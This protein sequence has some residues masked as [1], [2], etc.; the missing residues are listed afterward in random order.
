MKA[1]YQETLDKGIESVPKQIFDKFW[2]VYSWMASFS[3]SKF[4]HKRSTY[5]S[6]NTR[7]KDYS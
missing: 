3:S 4:P 6:T 1:T 7:D 5:V 2:L